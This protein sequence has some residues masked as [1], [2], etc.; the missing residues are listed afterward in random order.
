MESGKQKKWQESEI[1]LNNDSKSTHHC[2]R[3]LNMK[4]TLKAYAQGLMLALM[5]TITHTASAGQLEDGNAAYT[6]GDYAT[7]LKMFQPLA[8]QGYAPAQFN[9][10]AMYDHGRGVAKDYVEAYKWFNLSGVGGNE[11]AA[12]AR[13]LLE[14][15]MTQEQIAEAQRRAAAWKPNQ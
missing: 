15:R 11:D 2:P 7:A 12:E 6:R 1:K 10:G 14:S 8:N 3:G 5:L 13:I 4:N 9:L